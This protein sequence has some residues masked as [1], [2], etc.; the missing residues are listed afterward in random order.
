[1]ISN[2]TKGKGTWTGLSISDTQ[3]GR[4]LRCWLS[5]HHAGA[6]AVAPKY[7]P[8][9]ILIKEGDL[10]TPRQ[11]LTKSPGILGVSEGVWKGDQYF[12]GEAQRLRSLR[13]GARGDVRMRFACPDPCLSTHRA[14]RCRGLGLFVC[15]FVCLAGGPASFN[16][17]GPMAS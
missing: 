3:K 2:M 13:R 11:A 4:S 15:L 6:R 12:P 5:L 14:V 16:I 9:A 8:P 10:L 7:R 1:M 17:Q